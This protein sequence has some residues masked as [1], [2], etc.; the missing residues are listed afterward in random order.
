MSDRITRADLEESFRGVGR[1]ATG[2]LSAVRPVFPGVIGVAAG[3]LVV[4]AFVL[5]YRRGRVRSS[6]IEI[7]RI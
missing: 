1:S 2:A 4:A 5:G 7:T 6:V 3:V